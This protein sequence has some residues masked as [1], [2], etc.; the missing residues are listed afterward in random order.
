M[1]HLETENQSSF[2]ESAAVA[3][4]GFASLAIMTLLVHQS[5]H[6]EVQISVVMSPLPIPNLIL[7]LL[8]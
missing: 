7:T 6:E 1:A 5:C 4:D 3:F 8:Q 2:S